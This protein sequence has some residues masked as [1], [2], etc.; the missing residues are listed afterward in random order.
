MPSLHSG[1]SRSPKPPET[2]D[3][4]LTG[5]F[6]VLNDKQAGRLSGGSARTAPCRRPGRCLA[7]RLLA[8][9]VLRFSPTWRLCC[10]SSL[11]WLLWG[12]PGAVRSHRAS[13]APLCRWGPGP[14]LPGSGACFAKAARAPGHPARVLSPPRRLGRQISGHRA[15]AAAARTSADSASH[16]GLWVNSVSPSVEWRR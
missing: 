5:T 4:P 13:P 10:Q 2:L 9:E 7:G 1:S 11:A 15:G 8:P 3:V 12:F 14:G 6:D 16:S